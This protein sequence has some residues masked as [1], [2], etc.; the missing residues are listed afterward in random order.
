MIT[1]N[2]FPDF[3]T[4]GG[5]EGGTVAA[6]LDLPMVWECHLSLYIFL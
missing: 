4:V 6:P 2:C 1:Q 5:A 3:I